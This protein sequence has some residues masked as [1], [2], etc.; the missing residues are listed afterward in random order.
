MKTTLRSLLF[1]PGLIASGLTVHAQ[2]LGDETTQPPKLI[3]FSQDTDAARSQSSSFSPAS[4]FEQYLHL[5]EHNRFVPITSEK[6]DLGQMHQR[7]QQMYKGLKVEFG[8]A[9]LN[10]HDGTLLSMSNEC[11]QV[12]NVNTTPRLSAERALRSAMKFA[13]AQHYMWEDTEASAALGYEKP[14]GELLIFPNYDKVEANEKVTEFNL[15]YK[16]DLFCSQPLDRGNIYVD[17]HT[18]EILMYNPT[19]KHLGEHAHSVSSVAG[20]KEKKSILTMMA[21]GNAATRYNGTRPIEAR[22]TSRGFILQDATRGNGVNTYNSERTNRYPRTDFVDNDNNW[23]A[24]EHDNRFKDNAALNAHWGAERTYDYW[25]QIHSRNSWDGRGAAI[26][27]W[28]HY[29]NQPGGAGYDNA[30]W[31]GS[32]MTYGDGNSFDALVSIDVVAHEIGHAVCTAT[33]DLAYRRESGALNEGFSD[34]W[35]AAIEH[36][37]TAGNSSSVA[38]S[39]WLIGE[40]LGRNLRSMSDPNSRRDPDTYRGTNWK[41]ATVA[42]GCQT[43]SQRNDQCGVH[44]NSGVLNHW[45]YILTDGKSGTNDIGNSFT[46][47]GVGMIKAAKIAYRLESVYLGANSTFA[48]ARTFGIQS[49]I[50]LY[51]EGSAEEIATTN[52]WYAVGVGQ[53]YNGQTP[54]PPT[55]GPDTQAPTAPGTLTASKVTRTSVQLSWSASTDNVGVTGYD[56]FLGTRNLG[57]VTGTTEPVTGLSDNT[58]YTFRIRARDAAGNTSGFSNEVT[59]TTG[60]ETD[61]CAGVEPYSR[62]RRYNVGD[63]VTFQGSLFER[64]PTEWVNLGACSTSVTGIVGQK[65]EAVAP[66]FEALDASFSISPVPVTGGLL[67][68]SLDVDSDKLYTVRNL[69]GQT[70]MS[71]KVEGAINVSELSTGIYIIN[72]IAEGKTYTQKFV[73]E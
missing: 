42:E 54:N 1:L 47:N 21:A 71:G 19:I 32:V 64:R 56:I 39:V 17:A 10:S 68:V 29:D 34:I 65:N 44:S 57:T 40:D 52:A 30:F 48:N 67:T 66:P 70:V 45:F 18:G 73:I 24:A 61:I 69:V 59:I 49:A 28:V 12:Q 7:Y 51:G 22:Q 62:F 36:F 26:N 27:S 25:R 31:N 58:S 63:R 20:S 38:P 13:G 60:T 33:A 41:A 43:P 72:V 15:A 8:V 4:V 3:V 11:Y 5:P 37:A 16:F 50:D 6:D 9:T 35:G 2:Q 55:P 23:T 14:K 46:V 53:P